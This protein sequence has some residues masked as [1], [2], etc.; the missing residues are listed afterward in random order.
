MQ[1][2]VMPLRRKNRRKR[3]HRSLNLNF[4]RNSAMMEAGETSMIPQTQM[5]TRW[6]PKLRSGGTRRTHATSSTYNTTVKP[7]SKSR[8]IGT[9]ALNQCI[10]LTSKLHK[11]V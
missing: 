3:F 1:R 6:H 5:M 2:I 8:I 9:L 4:I 7:R 10:L 11:R